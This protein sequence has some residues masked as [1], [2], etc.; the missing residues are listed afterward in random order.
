MCWLGY[1]TSENVRRGTLDR[2]HRLIVRPHYFRTDQLILFLF[3]RCAGYYD[4]R[5]GRLKRNVFR[6][7]RKLVNDTTRQ[8]II[9][10][11]VILAG[12]LCTDALCEISNFH[13]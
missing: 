7:L 4:G 6:I 11:R 12:E 5:R 8:V 10:E 13:F 9:T 2:R 3:L 1:W